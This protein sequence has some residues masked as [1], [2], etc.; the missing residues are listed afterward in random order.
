MEQRSD[1]MFA[2]PRFAL[3]ILCTMMWYAHT[4]AAAD[5]VPPPL[6]YAVI[7]D[8]Q[9]P[10]GDALTDLRWAVAEVNRCAPRVVFVPGDL[11]N[12]AT[13]AQYRGV[14]S[15]YRE[16]TAPTIMVP[17]NHEGPCGEAV[18]R[19]RFT[20]FTGQSPYAHHEVGGWH[21]FALDSVFFRNGRLEHEGGVDAVQIDW[22][23]D[24]LKRLP[25]D[26]PIII[27]QHH[28]YNYP[29]QQVANEG[30][31]LD[32]F[33]NHRLLYTVTGH[34]HLNRFYRDA[35]AVQHIV[36]GS[37]SF[38]C[39]KKNCGIGYRLIATSGRDLWTAWIETSEVH[40]F[41]TSVARNEPL[42]PG[43][44]WKTVAPSPALCLRATYQGTGLRLRLTGLPPAKPDELKDLESVALGADGQTI[45]ITLPDVDAPT[46]ILVPL[47]ATSAKGTPPIELTPVG[48]KGRLNSVVLIATTATWQ[49]RRLKRPGE[50]AATVKLL[51]PR[52][53]TRVA[54]GHI[55]IVATV[56]GMPRNAAPEFFIDDKPVDI[57]AGAFVAILFDANGLQNKS[58]GFK[59]HLYVGDSL[60]GQIAPGRDVT[61]WET[62]AFPIPRA[63]WTET[64]TPAFR[65]TAGTPT[66]GTGANPPENNEDYAVTNLRLFDGAHT[67]VDPEIPLGKRVAIGDNGATPMTS[68]T[69][70]P[71]TTVERPRQTVIL[72]DWNAQT[73]PD[74]SATITVRVGTASASSTIHLTE[75]P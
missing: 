30:E 52:D 19:E 27:T 32:L 9:K 72:H 40:P 66:D 8:S 11:T 48:G 63:L 36:T 53:G 64:D 42:S 43:Q 34:K 41:G 14:M 25:E 16:L 35:E 62:F 51:S 60:I 33:A 54:R 47:P 3:A 24:E 21:V 22:I 7:A 45:E 4:V 58:Y 73:H 46:D 28:P 61:D 59:N 17:G 70:T 23:K 31:V 26:A 38:S 75:G 57:D 6:F 1:R 68:L 56:D 74:R 65:I 55:P 18:Y 12:N 13:E 5:A 15:V 67:R 2:R 69:C 44:T 71:A 37:I 20:E 49:H 50:T 39:D 10:D 29:A